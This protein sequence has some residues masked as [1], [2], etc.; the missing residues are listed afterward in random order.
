MNLPVIEM[1]REEAERKYQTYREQLRRV[2]DDEVEAIM[3]GYKEL[4]RGHR[5]LRLSEAMQQGGLDHRSLPRLAICRADEKWCKMEYRNDWRHNR[6]TFVGYKD[7]N[8]RHHS[9]L[10][11]RVRFEPDIFGPGAIEAL[12]RIRTN[13]GNRRA[14]V[15]IVPP[16]L[17]PAY[18]LQNYHILWEADWKPERVAAAPRDPA[19]LKRV[20]GDLF[21]VLAVWDLTELERAVLAGRE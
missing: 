13:I 20:G 6:L 9:A 11:R 8:D 19:L 17:R 5:L 4:S 15:P 16:P 1:E 12:D 14:M 18:R 21:S 7:I 2:H 3:R 10:S